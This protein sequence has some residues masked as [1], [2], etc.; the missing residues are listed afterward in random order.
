M[1][2]ILL[3]DDN[4]IFREALAET[5]RRA[6]Y[7]VIQAHDGIDGERIFNEEQIDLVITDIFMPEQDGLSTINALRAKNDKVKVIAMSGGGSIMSHSDYLSHAKQ[8]GADAI[9]Y[10]SDEPEELIQKVKDL[11]T[12]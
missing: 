6:A 9:H 7:E 12:D 4:E 2:K 8:F 5:L 10:K 11:L 3:I 1:A